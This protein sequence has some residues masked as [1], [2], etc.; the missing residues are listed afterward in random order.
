M[1]T[2]ANLSIC[3]ALVVAAFAIPFLH[4]CSGADP[5]TKPTVEAPVVLKPLTEDQLFSGELVK[6]ILAQKNNAINDANKLFLQALDQYKNKKDAKGAIPL[7]IQAICKY[8]ENRSYYELGNACLDA[9][10]LDRSLQCYEMAEKLGYEPFSKVLYNMA[11]VYSR[12]EK[13]QTAAKYLEYSIQAGYTNLDHITADK[14]LDHLRKDEYAYRE[15]INRGMRGMSNP[16]AL[17][18]LQFR[19]PF[20]KVQFPFAL[21]GEKK[22]YL[23]KD[24]IA[25]DFEKYIPEMRDEKFSREVGRLFYSSAELFAT[26]K[27]IALLYAEE[28]PFMEDLSPVLYKLVTFTPEGKIID[29]KDI[30]G[31][32]FLEDP[33]MTAKITQNRVICIKTYDLT[34]EKDPGE[35]GFENNPVK[36]KTLSGTAYFKINDNGTISETNPV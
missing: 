3:V 32:S 12:Q 19:K 11:C 31:H 34:Y 23:D 16:K 27:F 22:H 13:T 8:P 28:R 25:Y 9:G 7:F 14:D 10:E 35:E 1:R 30:A 36:S 17:F 4:S 24:R 20:A 29:R 5:A 33:L 2:H 6:R 18:W 15:A 21:N 26:D